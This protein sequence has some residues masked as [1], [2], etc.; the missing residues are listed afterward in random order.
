MSTTSEDT[1]PGA[2]RTVVLLFLFMAINSADKAVLGL[3]AVPIMR[4]LGL[5]P[6][7]FGFIGSS[8]F[9]LYSLSAIAVGFAVD[10]IE[11][12]LAILLMSV[13]W[14][15]TLLPMTW[16]VGFWTLV[17][18]RVMLGAGEGP[19]YPVALHAAYKWFPD[20]QR[21]LPTAIIAQGAAIGVVVAAPLLN[22][23]IVAHSWHIA[24]TALAIAGFLWSAAWMLW[25]AEGPLA[26]SRDAASTTAH[27]GVSYHQLLCNRTFVS[28]ALAAF[29]AY[30]VL[31][32][33]LVWL[34]PFLVQGV[35]LSQA[36]AGPLS[37]LPWAFGSVVVI[38]AGWW[39]ELLL[40][41]GT[42]SRVARGIMGAAALT[43]GGLALIATAFISSKWMLIAGVAIGAALPGAV[44]VLCP[45]VIAQFTPVEKRGAVLAIYSAIYTFAGVLAPY[46][47]GLLI[48][49]SG[50][51]LAGYQN[52]FLLAGGLALIGGLATLIG[53]HPDREARA[54]GTA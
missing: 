6:A 2:W 45:S 10:R 13:V 19:A 27:S 9:F 50:S 34:T 3:A 46:V 5:S 1:L 18:C 53:V 37:A 33:G 20:R 8:F 48:E 41:S 14:A 42:S 30:W 28:C 51:V 29:S 44:Y 38:A 36:E 26:K 40:R 11:T 52:A 15:L 47:S 17:I 32:F 12:R 22:H 21:T 39:S 25:G 31:S 43:A 16:E 23:L 54:F 4:D 24:F 7:E 35:G 49:H